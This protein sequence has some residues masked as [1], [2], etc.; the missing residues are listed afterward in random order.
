M[1]SCAESATAVKAKGRSDKIA[2]ASP[3]KQSRVKSDRAMSNPGATQEQPMT[4]ETEPNVRQAVPFFMVSNMEASLRFYIDGLG[5]QRINQWIVDN[6]IRWCWL[7][8][9]GAALM[10]QEYRPDKIPSNKR[11]E[12]VT[13]CFQCR[14]AL[15][16]YHE[17]LARGLAPRR[18]F[19]GNNMW[20]T[21]LTDPDGYKLEF[22][23]PTTVPEETVYSDD[24]ELSTP[25]QK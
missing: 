7:Q 1:K 16:I 4:F 9:G 22:A 15:A 5:F 3:H 14:D 21:A 6:K 8:L 12:G 11:G 13:L 18:P 10:L 24:L 20:V 19:V 17:T 25:A 2:P 23:S